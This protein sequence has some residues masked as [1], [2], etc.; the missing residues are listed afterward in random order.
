MKKDITEK[1][2]ISF[3]ENILD[4][5][6]EISLNDFIERVSKSFNLSSHDLSKSLTRPVELM[7]EQRCRN[8]VSHKNFPKNLIYYVDG[9]FKAR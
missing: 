2:L 8:I 5:E 3:L 9:I 6:G 7:F 1:N 4:V